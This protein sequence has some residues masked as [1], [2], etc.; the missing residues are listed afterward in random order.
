MKLPKGQSL[1]GTWLLLC[2]VN[3]ISITKGKLRGRMG[4]VFTKGLLRV[5]FPDGCWGGPRELVWYFVWLG[6]S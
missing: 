2:S 6:I 1:A 4:Q 3:F 5:T